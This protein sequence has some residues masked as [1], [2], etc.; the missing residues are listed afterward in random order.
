MRKQGVGSTQVL[1]R[2]E[3]PHRWP[4][5]KRAPQLANEQQLASE[6]HARCGPPHGAARSRSATRRSDDNIN[7]GQSRLAAGARPPPTRPTPR[8]RS[9]PPSTPCTAAAPRRAGPA[10]LGG[11][12]SGALRR[13]RALRRRGAAPRA[14]A[15]VRR[16]ARG[17]APRA[18]APVRSRARGAPWPGTPPQTARRARAG[19]TRPPGWPWHS[20]GRA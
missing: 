11:R 5:P 1:P 10:L 2:S 6:Q 7:T 19:A 13:A 17:A 8:A 20:P 12:A 16:R 9:Q 14:A 18:A 15:L 4:R 3:T